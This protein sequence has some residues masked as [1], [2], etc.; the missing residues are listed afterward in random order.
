MPG[1][2]QVHFKGQGRRS[3]LLRRNYSFFLTEFL[4]SCLIISFMSHNHF[5]IFAGGLIGIA[6]LFFG[7]FHSFP[8]RSSF[9]PVAFASSTH[10]LYWGAYIAGTTYG[11]SYGTAPWDTKTWDMFESHTGKKVS[12]LHFG[13]AWYTSAYYPYGYTPFPTS[14]VDAVRSRGAIPMISWGSWD[15]SLG[16][17]QSDFSLKH[18]A[19]GGSY[20]YK[21]KTF[22]AYVTAWAQA[23]KQ[24]GHPLF[25]R[26]D[27]EM[28]G[29]WQFPWA[30]A[31][32]PSTHVVINGNTPADYVAA[33]RHVHDIFTK[34]GATNVTWVWCPNLSSAN[35]VPLS[36]LYPG[37]QYVD[38]VCLDVYNKD[39]NT[40]ASFDMLMRANTFTANHDSYAEITSLAPGKPLMLGEMASREA[41][42]GG[43]KKAAWIADT[44]TKI[45]T[46]YPSIDAV[47][48]F[49]WNSDG[50]QYVIES[51]A[52]SQ[53]AFVTAIGASAFATNVFGSTSVFPIP[54]L[55]GQI[56]PPPTIPPAPTPL[57]ATP[58]P[59]ATSTPKPTITPT[60]KPTPLPTPKPTV[61]PT[62]LATP[63]PVTTSVSITTPHVNA[64][65]GMGSTVV[66]Q[67][68]APTTTLKVDFLVNNQVICSP[69]SSYVYHCSWKVPLV[70]SVTYTL[71]ARATDRSG[72]VSTSTPVRI[73][74]K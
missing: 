21:G 5:H 18:I 58:K 37:S 54:P 50:N 24:W 4:H 43:V 61:A 11:G 53:H 33:W 62:P 59:V 16:P 55:S 6:L 49:N 32:N 15:E 44:F 52:L 66:I 36:S 27:H 72:K 31:P 9:S 7:I 39:P 60:P 1:L 67:A 41:G 69:T 19:N 40:W 47:V 57:P 45:Q 29:W 38:W 26:F 56:I 14:L 71:L 20:T 10:P 35:T 74:A 34:V 22:D 8:P 17:N 65:V 73:M 68:S 30:T 64:I 12:I 2:Y 63:M 48:W 3:N 25:V 42:D 70:S 28:N 46:S 51:S 13:Q 23:A